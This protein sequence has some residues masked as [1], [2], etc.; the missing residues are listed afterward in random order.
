MVD[1][2]PDLRVS[3]VELLALLDTQ[4]KVYLVMEPATRGDEVQTPG[5]YLTDLL[6]DVASVPEMGDP[7]AV[8]A[9]GK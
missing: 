9:G 3:P 5:V 8:F 6:P 7:G 4:A 2:N 1:P